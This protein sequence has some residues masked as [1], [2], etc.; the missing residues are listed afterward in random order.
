[1]SILVATDFSDASEAAVRTAVRLSNAR[2][3]RLKLLH[4]VDT[5]P[6]ESPWDQAADL[7]DKTETELRKS[8]MEQFEEFFDDLIPALDQPKEVEFRVELAAASDA[9][10][11]LAEDD[12]EEV[13]L[14]V[15]GAT[16]R[17]RVMNF[18]LG[19]TAEDV[20]RRSHRPVL[21][22]PEEAKTGAWEHI[23]AP[24]GFSDCSRASLE[25]AAETAREEGAALEVLHAYFPPTAAAPAGMPEVPPA[26]IETYEQRVEERFDGF[27]ADTDLSGLET[28]RK[29]SVG[30]P[31]DAVVEAVEESGADLVVM[32]THGRQGVER[33]FLGS[34][35]AKVLRRMPCPVMTLRAD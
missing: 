16:G 1:M 25:Y 24:V 29:L 28:T 20:V 18:L 3:Q 27:L 7:P 6:G 23:L 35:A 8:A 22:V 26:N 17:S 14:V 31:A 32:G 5:L 19:S 34:T 21:V 10:V 4:C 33:L 11:E 9:I 15:V 13:E 2:K 12:E 30:S